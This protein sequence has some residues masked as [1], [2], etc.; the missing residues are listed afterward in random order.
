MGREWVEAGERMLRLLDEMDV[1]LAELQ[2]L[3][4]W[5]D[6]RNLPPKARALLQGCVAS[7]DS[8]GRSN[9]AVRETLQEARE[10]IPWSL[11]LEAYPEDLLSRT[12]AQLQQVAHNHQTMLAV[13]NLCR[14]YAGQPVSPGSSLN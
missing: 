11:P 4:L 9:R 7:M 13:L 3:P 14:S 10:R 1:M 8:M 2:A 5:D 12:T 6:A